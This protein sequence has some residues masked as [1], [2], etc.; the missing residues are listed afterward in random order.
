MDAG[1]ILRGRNEFLDAI[2]YLEAT[3]EK[4]IKKEHFER[5]KRA[6]YSI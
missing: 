5:L 2:F 4:K 6:T 1:D 3:Y